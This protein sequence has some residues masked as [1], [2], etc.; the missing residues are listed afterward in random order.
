MSH[1]E[2]ALQFR[3]VAL[4]LAFWFLLPRVFLTAKKATAFLGSF[5]VAGAGRPRCSR[6][7]EGER[8]RVLSPSSQITASK[9]KS[10]VKLAEI[11]GLRRSPAA[12][13]RVVR[14][15][16]GRDGARW[17]EAFRIFRGGWW[18]FFLRAAFGAD[19]KL[20]TMLGRVQRVG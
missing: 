4:V 3:H 18:A 14:L 13:I 8:S 6:T 12:G 2:E 19:E 1:L 20:R 16:D 9:D 11:F 10:L 15:P 17:R 5:E 7:R